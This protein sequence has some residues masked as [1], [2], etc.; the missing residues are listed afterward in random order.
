M[1]RLHALQ[2]QLLAAGDGSVDGVDGVL[3][4]REKRAQRLP[5]GW[6]PRVGITPWRVLHI[7]YPKP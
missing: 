4:P 6:Q 2:R 1:E 5:E 3:Q 7:P